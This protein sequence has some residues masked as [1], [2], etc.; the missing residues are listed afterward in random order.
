MWPNIETENPWDLGV[1]HAKQWDAIVTE[2]EKSLCGVIG[3]EK[4]E[5]RIEVWDTEEKT[6]EILM[7]DHVTGWRA[8]S[9]FLGFCAS[10]YNL[11]GVSETTTTKFNK[12][13]QEFKIAY[14]EHAHYVVEY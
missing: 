12:Y 4:G 7:V 3:V 13:L 10:H 5:E 11:C 8:I 2:V 14:P 1:Y 6:I 9:D